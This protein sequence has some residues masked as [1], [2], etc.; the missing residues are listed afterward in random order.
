MTEKKDYS[1]IAKEAFIGTNL[2]S[3]LIISL[4]DVKVAVKG[5]RNWSA[6]GTD[7]VYGFWLKYI[8]SCHEALSRLMTEAL[9]NPDTIDE[10]VTSFRTLLI[11]KTKQPGPGNFRPIS[12]MNNVMKLVTSDHFHHEQCDEAGLEGDTSN[13]QAY[14]P[15][16]SVEQRS[17]R[18][19]RC[20]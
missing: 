12:I 2:S 16:C 13:Y 1:D 15:G 3:P 19:L 18:S 6:A 17:P 7:Q 10:S 11:A 9:V 20:E 8:S 4:E 14:P 5:T